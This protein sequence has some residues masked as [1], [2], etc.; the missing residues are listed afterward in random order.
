MSTYKQGQPHSDIF[1][2]VVDESQGEE[3]SHLNGGEGV[4]SLDG[5]P[6]QVRLVRL[7]FLRHEEQE[8]P[9]DHLESLGGGHAH[10]E[11]DAEK[12]RH[13]DAVQDGGHEDGDPDEDVDEEGCDALFADAEEFRLFSGH[14][15]FGLLLEG[16]D[17][18]DG[19]HGGGFA[20]GKA[21]ERAHADEEAADEEVEMEAAAFLEQVFLPVDDDHGNLLVHEDQDG[22]EHGHAKG[23]EGHVPGIVAEQG[24]PSRDDQ[25]S[26]GRSRGRPV[27]GSGHPK[28]SPS[29]LPR[30]G[31]WPRRSGRCWR[32]RWSG[33][34]GCP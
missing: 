20:P 3:T 25:W 2:D 18:V 13:G 8:Q 34:R 31:R 6:P 16:V 24:G 17:V 33:S 29:L 9:I 19:G 4:H 15:G 11:E 10:V 28:R 22:A 27:L 5:D 1:V 32:G 26:V 7:V 12:D 23:N 21:E 14:G 30:R